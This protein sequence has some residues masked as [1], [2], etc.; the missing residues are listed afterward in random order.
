LTQS[1]ALIAG[2][3]NVIISYYE[4]EAAAE[5]GDEDSDAYIADPEHYENDPGLNEPGTNIQIIYARVESGTT[6]N[7][8]YVIVPIELEVVPAP[9]LNP[10]GDPF[11][12]T[13]CADG[14]EATAELPLGDLPYGLYDYTDGAPADLIPLLDDDPS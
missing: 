11:G 1:G 12:Y 5:T 2:G 9:R 14:D 13:L 3:E 6:G 10:L 7:S 4:T 8:C